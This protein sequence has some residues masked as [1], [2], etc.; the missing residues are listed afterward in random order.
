M[1]SHAS[2]HAESYHF[3]RLIPCSR[4]DEVLVVRQ[5]K[6]QFR[7]AFAPV[8]SSMYSGSDL[9]SLGVRDLR[10]LSSYVPNFVLPNYGSRYTSSI[11]VRG[12]GSRFNS[13]AVGY[14]CRWHAIDEQ[15]GFQHSQLTICR[16]SNVLRGSQAPLYGLNSE[17]GLVRIYTKKPHELSGNRRETQRRHTFYRNADVSHYQKLSDR[18]AFSVAGFYEGRTFFQNQ[19]LNRRAD[20]YDEGGGRLKLVFQPTRRWDINVLADYQYTHQNGFS[21]RPDG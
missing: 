14:L 12:T 8:S 16:V 19:T 21:V 3:E 17:A 15:V 2:A 10:E 13:P 11:Y 6:E 4:L 9:F 1:A 18:F 20:N 5:P 7:L